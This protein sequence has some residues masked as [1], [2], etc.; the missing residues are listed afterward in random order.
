MPTI[1]I[2]SALP[3]FSG[4]KYF[5]MKTVRGF[6]P[7]VHCARC[8][9]G[10]YEQSVKVKMAVNQPTELTAVDGAVVYLCGVADPF[11]WERNLHLAAMVKRGSIATVAAYTGD[12]ICLLDCETIN[13]NDEAATRLFPELGKAFLTCRNFQFGAHFYGSPNQKRTAD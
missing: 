3:T 12:V 9:L 1:E 8:L 5:W 7:L 11:R 4:F 13:F 6:N 10:S 2:K